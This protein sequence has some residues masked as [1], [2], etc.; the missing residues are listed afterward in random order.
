MTTVGRVLAM[1]VRE[2]RLLAYALLLVVAFRI[3]LSV[4]PPSRIRRLA[5]R[6]VA[7]SSSLAD[8]SPERLAWA[9]GAVA[10]RVPRA[11]CLTQAFALHRLL[12]RAGHAA[13]IRVGV[14]KGEQGSL[15]S[16][17]W[18]VCQGRILV[19][20]RDDLGRYAPILSLGMERP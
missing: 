1:P 15:D 5:G 4:M 6:S 13:E 20:K 10:R 2:Q 18:V 8:F 12:A 16:H 19:G 9:V 14:A 7:P 3:A 17:A 11:S